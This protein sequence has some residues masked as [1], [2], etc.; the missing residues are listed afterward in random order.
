MVAAEKEA[1]R[2]EEERKARE[3]KE[4]RAREARAKKIAK[5]NQVLQTPKQTVSVIRMR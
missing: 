2:N 1:K 5:L 3:E 4:Q